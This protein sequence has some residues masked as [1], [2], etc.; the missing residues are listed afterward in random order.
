MPNKSIITG[1]H[2]SPVLKA[3][4]QELRRAMTP[5]ESKLWEELRANRL[6]G[7]HFRRQQII[8]SFIVDFYCHAVGLVVE[9]DGGIHLAQQADDRLRDAY[10]QDLGLTVLRFNNEVV[11]HQL[12]HVLATIHAA[13]LLGE[14][15]SADKE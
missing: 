9:V 11:E 10:L 14:S 4:A 2:I 13:C 3:R 5:A 12:N 8:G 7:F 1:Q 6:N 15:Q